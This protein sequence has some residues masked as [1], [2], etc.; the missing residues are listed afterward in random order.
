VLNRLMASLADEDV[1]FGE[2]AD[3]MEKDTVM[4]GNVLRMVNSALY[5]WSGT[6]NSVRHAVALM[7][8][9][10]L[11]NTVMTL[12]VSR[13]LNHKEVPP[14]WSSSQFN[15]HGAA[16]AILADL[17]AAEMDI[18]YPEG[19]FT[20][21]LLQNVGMLLIA[22]SHPKEHERIRDLCARGCQDLLEAEQFVLGVDHTELS[23]EALA[24]W[25][26]PVPIREAVRYHHHPEEAEG[27]SSLARVVAAA[28]YM[29]GLRGIPAQSWLIPPQGN[30]L[31]ALEE[32]GLADRAER[33]LQAFENE[34]EVTCH[35]FK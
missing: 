3:L 13:M 20:A 7:G 14:S 1:S 5:A 16:S 9:A 19:A 17:L 25:N 34:Y 27:G 26:L 15:L 2:V 23:A 28:D 31:D 35:F 24:Q 10:K 22:I 12:S 18:E 30:L 29:A 33:I 8:M 11:R 4:A 32:L 21:G 6:V